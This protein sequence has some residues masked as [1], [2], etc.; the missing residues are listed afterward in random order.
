MAAARYTRTHVRSLGRAE[1][2]PPRHRAR[3]GSGK[4]LAGIRVACHSPSGGD[5]EVFTD[6]QGRFEI[7]GIPKSEDYT[8][9]VGYRGLP[10]IPYMTTVGDTPGLQ[11]IT[12]N[13]E[14]ER[15]LVFR[16]RVTEKDTNKPVQGY[17]EYHIRIDNPSLAPVKSFLRGTVFREP[18]DKDGTFEQV[19]VPGP[20]YIGFRATLGHFARSRLKG[21]E[22]GRFLRDAH[23][24]PPME[25]LHAVVPINP[26]AEDAKSLTCHIVL[27]RGRTLSGTVAD[28]QGRPLSGAMVC[29]LNAVMSFASTREEDALLETPNFT[30]TGLDLK[31]PRTLIFYHAGKKL[32]KTL[33]LHG[34]EKGPVTVRLEPLGALTG[35]VVAGDGKPAS[36][37]AASLLFE[38]KQEG[39]LPWEAYYRG[40]P[41]RRALL[42]K[43]ATTDKDGRFRIEGLVAGLKYDLAISR[44]EEGIR[45]RPKRCGR[46]TRRDGGRGRDQDASALSSDYDQPE[47]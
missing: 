12:R 38:E 23:L 45:S 39:A 18:I 22:Q 24:A 41:F 6:K 11:P 7:P 28:A 25:M 42:S 9:S 19:V 26:S 14:M 36:G 3:K 44:E 10:Y 31:Y 27:E 29:G 43:G 2:A 37:V 8:L 20:G 13:F 4:P 15:G 46:Q 30:A 21:R 40:E 34:D 32:A 1:Q 5:V 35:R 33:V 16:V 17:L 47:A